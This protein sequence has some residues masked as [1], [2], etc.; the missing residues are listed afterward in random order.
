MTSYGIGVWVGGWPAAFALAFRGSCLL[1]HGEDEILF[2]FLATF[3]GTGAVG[4]G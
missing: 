4:R 2:L 1:K 3:Q